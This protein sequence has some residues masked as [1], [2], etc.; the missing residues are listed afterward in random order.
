MRST[1]INGPRVVELALVVDAPVVHTRIY[2]TPSKLSQ[3]R[4]L[5]GNAAANLMKQPPF[6]TGTEEGVH[7]ANYD[8][9]SQN[10]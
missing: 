6:C 10:V 5:T 8:E 4:L 1:A 9:K 3:F 2:C 7:R